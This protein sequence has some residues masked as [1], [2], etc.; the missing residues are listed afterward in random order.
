MKQTSKRSN[1]RQ[2]LLFNRLGGGEI[3]KFNQ[4]KPRQ[5]TNEHTAQHLHRT[6]LNEFRANPPRLNTQ[7]Q[8]QT[9]TQTKQ[10]H[11]YPIQPNNRRPQH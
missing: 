10:N 8:T 9:Q 1:L 5:A 4:I 2:D 3:F 6:N 11:V 7:T